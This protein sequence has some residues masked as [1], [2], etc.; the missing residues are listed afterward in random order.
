MSDAL[1]GRIQLQLPACRFCSQ[2]VMD[3]DCYQDVFDPLNGGFRRVLHL[4]NPHLYGRCRCEC[5]GPA[6]P[7]VVQGGTSNAPRL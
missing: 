4:G 2:G 3:A 7:P 5:H 1:P 6:R